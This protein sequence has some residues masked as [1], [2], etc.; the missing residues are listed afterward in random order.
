MLV[1]PV[2]SAIDGRKA[3]KQQE[4]HQWL[5]PRSNLDCCSHRSLVDHSEGEHDTPQGPRSAVLT[6]RKLVEVSG[7]RKS[8]PTKTQPRVRVWAE[9]GPQTG[10]YRRHDS[11]IL[12]QRVEAAAARLLDGAQGSAATRAAQHDAA[13][14]WGM[15]GAA[16]VP[17]LGLTV[18]VKGG[19]VQWLWLGGSPWLHEV[20][21]L[22]FGRGSSPRH[23]GAREGRGRYKLN[24]IVEDETATANFTIFG[25]L[26]QDLIQ[27]P[28]SQLATATNAD[29]YTL[30]PI[31][32]TILGSTHIFQIILSTPTFNTESMSF[33]VVRILSPPERETAT[34]SEQF[35]SSSSYTISSHNHTQQ[36]KRNRE[37]QLELYLEHTP[38]KQEMSIPDVTSPY[39]NSPKSPEDT[40]STP[41]AKK[42]FK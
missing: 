25:K 40:V 35:T 37:N 6:L 33:K 38:S 34:T 13:A 3:S 28:A 36:A 12:D 29:R 9:L 7:G 41:P 24:T 32:S 14:S 18:T 20:C 5:E 11:M 23:G 19:A 4:I 30:P 39:A 21:G 42:I 26:A 2:R 16:P 31:I 15:V 10:N 22:S 27:I 1:L 8:E 17:S